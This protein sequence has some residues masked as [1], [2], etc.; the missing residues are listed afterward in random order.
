MNADAPPPRRPFSSTTAWIRDR[1]RQS[2]KA[3]G[4]SPPSGEPLPQ[5]IG[6]YKVIERIGR[7]SVANVYRAADEAGRDVAVKVI[8][9]DQAGPEAEAVFKREAAILKG[10]SHPDIV[11]LREIAR[12]NEGLYLAMDY[13]PGPTLQVVIEHGAPREEQLYL[14]MRVARAVH[15]AHTHGI[16]HRDLKP[17][18]ILIGPDGPI[19]TDFGIARAM[20]SI[21]RVKNQPPI[22]TPT[23]MAPEQIDRRLAAI[24]PATDIWALGV[25]LY[26]ILCRRLPFVDIDAA[27]TFRRVLAEAPRP[28]RRIDASVP[29]ALEIVCLH[30]LQKTP[31]NRYA[32]AE[33]FADDLERGAT[34]QPIA[35][36]GP[37]LKRLFRWFTPRP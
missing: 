30:A 22:G 37:W 25:I 17:Q 10:L 4:A 31:E 32:T 5:N 19:V 7:G 13:V 18:N 6:P 23:H 3:K 8:R 12:A 24:G 29:A 33:A 28:P 34:G 35:Q 14:L 36:P 20:D 15:Y 21:T 1:F 26:T 16:V 9:H 11:V 2:I 27:S